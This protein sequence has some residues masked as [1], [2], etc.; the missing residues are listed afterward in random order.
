M[1]VAMWRAQTP[2]ELSSLP[3]S[4]V[5]VGVSWGSFGRNIDTAEQCCSERLHNIDSRLAPTIR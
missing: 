4:A 3:A 1:V 2:V 5:S